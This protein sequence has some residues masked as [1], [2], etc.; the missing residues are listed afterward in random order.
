M[1][2]RMTGCTVSIIRK[3]T[4]WLTRRKEG[5]I[6]STGLQT[7]KTKSPAWTEGALF[8]EGQGRLGFMPHGVRIT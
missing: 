7:E 1:A 3:A 6:G 5:R 4:R 8:E 2:V